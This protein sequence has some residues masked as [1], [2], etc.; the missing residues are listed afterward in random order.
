[1]NIFLY[2][3]L[4]HRG[5]SSVIDYALSVNKPFGISDSNMF[6]HIYS[7]DI[8]LYKTIIQTCMINSKLFIE[9]FKKINSHINVINKF[10]DILI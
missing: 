6:K 1:M 5:I 7:D 8:C 3:K 4:E 9:Q 2:D 10:D